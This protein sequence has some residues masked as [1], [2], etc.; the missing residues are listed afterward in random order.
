MYLKFN[1]VFFFCL[2]H[3]LHL[4]FGL[5]FEAED[6]RREEKTEDDFQVAESP[7]TQSAHPKV[8]EKNLRTG[9]GQ[10]AA[11]VTC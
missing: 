11:V 1:E 6:E 3:Q 10:E 2:W 4:L 9:M 8:A 5:K 7:R